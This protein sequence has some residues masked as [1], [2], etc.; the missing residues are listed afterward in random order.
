MI[1]QEYGNQMICI[2]IDNGLT[3]GIVA[4]DENQL[5][6]SNPTYAKNQPGLFDDETGTYAWIMPV[7]KGKGKNIYDIKRIVKILTYLKNEA[8][9]NRI[10]M[11]AI[12]E[13]AHIL[14][15][16][17][18]RANFTTGEC[19]GMMQGIL[20]ALNIP[21]EIVSAKMW[22][23]RIFQGQTVTDTKQS[24]ILFCQN[25]FPKVDWRISPRGRK[26]HDGKTDAACMAVYCHRLH[27]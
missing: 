2:G 10:P 1:R 11:Y 25:K 15:K 9:L 20:S 24:S 27:K 16:N 12:L 21:Y 4:V 14:P 23:Q 3:G 17:G 7:I 13:K 26:A 6:H 19:F 18:G 5:I 8:Q 22:Q